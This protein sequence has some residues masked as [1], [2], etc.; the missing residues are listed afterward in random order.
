MRWWQEA[1]LRVHSPSH[2]IG[3]L[4]PRR[5]ETLWSSDGT[6]EGSFFLWKFAGSQ[7]YWGSLCRSG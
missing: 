6:W 5:P 1:K 2:G 7:V 3:D 4:P